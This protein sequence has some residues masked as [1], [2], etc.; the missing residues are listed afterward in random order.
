MKLILVHPPDGKPRLVREPRVR[1]KY[2]QV[3]SD[4][5]SLGAAEG[6]IE[7]APD[8][9]GWI[10]DRHLGRAISIE[11]QCVMDLIV[12]DQKLGRFRDGHA[13]AATQFVHREQHQGLVIP[14]E[15]R[16]GARPE[17]VIPR[18]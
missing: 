13:L 9:R 3:A 15:T 7:Q 14:S 16:D 1:R 2:R 6:G 8:V 5:T 10:L 17:D 4:R 12:P 18:S 11:I